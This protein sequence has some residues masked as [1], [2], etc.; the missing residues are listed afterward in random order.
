[1]GVF[2]VLVLIV[3]GILYLGQ[4]FRKGVYAKQIADESAELRE[5]VISKC[6]RNDIDHQEAIKIA[7]NYAED[8]HNECYRRLNMTWGSLFAVKRAITG[9]HVEFQSEVDEKLR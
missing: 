7:N 9:I 1:M 8:F 4:R 5:Y 3:V 6:T 2:I